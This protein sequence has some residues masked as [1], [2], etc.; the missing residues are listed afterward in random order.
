MKQL[1][2]CLRRAIAI[3]VF[4]TLS[5]FAQTPTTL[6]TDDFSDGNYTTNWEWVVT[7]GTGAV[8]NQEFVLSGGLPYNDAWAYTLGDTTKSSLLGTHYGVY[9]NVRI[10]GTGTPASTLNFRDDAVAYW[11]VDLYPDNGGIYLLRGV[12]PAAAEYITWVTGLTKI[13]IGQTIKALVQVMEDTLRVKTWL[14]PFE[15]VDWDLEYVDTT[16]MGT[17]WPGIQ[18]GGWYL[19]NANV[20]YDNFEVVTYEDVTSVNDVGAG[21]APGDF[22]LEQNYPNPFNPSTTIR[23]SVPV[24]DQVEIGIYDLSGRKVRTLANEQYGAGTHSVVWNGTNDYGDNVPSG[25][26]FYR[27]KGGHSSATKKL[28]LMK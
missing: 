7:T 24:A 25:I 8:T 1:P 27:M 21:A 3:V 12:Y 9:Y 13:Q 4:L 6:W 26:Y 10:E 19:D 5:I 18:I 15:P 28:V 2:T 20:I 17:L 23:F 22:V 11:I 16:S 14:G